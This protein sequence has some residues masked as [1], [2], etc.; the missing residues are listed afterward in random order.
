MEKKRKSLVGRLTGRF[1]IWM[2]IIV[3]IISYVLFYL[4]A[5]AT[6]QFYSEIYHNKMLVT[7]EYTRRVISDV[8]VAVTNNLYYLEH[9]LDKPDNHRVTMEQIVKSGTRVRSCGV[10]FIENY[11][12]QKGQQYCP[13]AWRDAANPD[14]VHSQDKSDTGR[15]Y[16]H[17]DWFQGVLRSDSAQWS[18]PRYRPIWCPFTTR[19][20]A[21]WRCLEQTSHWIGLPKS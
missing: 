10:S 4:E 13:Y 5:Q 17:A 12:P 19:P 9:S 14:S 8:Y 3:I 6:R 7:N 15:D 2:T 18:A 20:G 16:L 11:Y 21:S 1:L